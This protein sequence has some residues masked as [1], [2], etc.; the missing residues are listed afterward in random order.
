MTETTTPTTQ[1]HMY[2]R[3]NA[4]FDEGWTDH[5]EIAELTG[6]KKEYVYQTW[7][8]RNNPQLVEKYKMTRSERDKK[9]RLRQIARERRALRRAMKQNNVQP[10]EEPLPTITE[11][12]AIPLPP[13]PEEIYVDVDTFVAALPPEDKEVMAQHEGHFTVKKDMVNSPSHYTHGGIETIDYIRAKLSR[14]E[15]IGYLRG[16]ILKYTSRLGM[17]DSVVQEA[18]KLAWYTREL[19]AFLE[20]N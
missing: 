18:G 8:N 7:W 9:N 13:P 14:E 19:A 2:Q 4:L 17:K 6:A 10:I 1:P 20:N 11:Q 12:L 3:I 5:A 15:Y 16:N